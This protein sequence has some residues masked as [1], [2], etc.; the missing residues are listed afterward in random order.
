MTNSKHLNLDQIYQYLLIALAFVF[1]LTVAGGNL[2][3]S[4]I[5]LTWL[6]SGNY[7]AKFNQ[8]ISNKLAVLSILFFSLHVLGLLW[9]DD[10]KWGLTIVKKMSDFLFL[11]PILLTITKKE[12]I[13]HYISAFILAMTLTEL[14]S[15][16]VWFEVI[17]SLHKAT[18]GNPTPTM[19]H[20]S[21]NPF[22][23]FGIYL[24][25]H[26]ILFNKH[27][28]KLS[29]YIYVFFIVTMSINMFITGGR[30]GQVMYFVMLGIL[31][32]QY[33]GRERKVRAAIISLI[34]IPSIFFGAYNSSDIFQHRMDEAVKN[35]SIYNTDGNKNTSVGQRITYTINSL[36][37]I[38]NNLFFGVGTGDFPSEYNKIH[39]KNTPG[40]NT[41]VNPHNMYILVAVQ[42]GL[43]GLLGMLLIFYQQ[44]KFS[45]SAKIKIN[46]DLGIVLP[47]LFLV[48]MFSDSYLLGHY[49]TILFVFFSSF[50]YKDFEKN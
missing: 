32:F 1:P 6:L 5:V 25:A 13:S 23:T 50:L 21:Y 22:L 33:Y 9:T 8:I 31:I 49:T 28:A 16:L 15:Y 14:L 34:I 29:K 18:A 7:K 30:A 45:L 43:F 27:L 42:L 46:R 12:Y 44:I 10:L 36:E 24:I 3:I 20:I 39:V 37:I 41:T 26:E 40:V 38:K 4:I 17:G 2:I 11:L 35:I 47:L 48:I 19:S